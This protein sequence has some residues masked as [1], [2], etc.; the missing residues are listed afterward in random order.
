MDY[1]LAVL[2][3]KF[4]IKPGEVNHRLT[5]PVII[6][7]IIYLYIIMPARRKRV[8]M[9]FKFPSKGL[10]KLKKEVKVI[11]KMVN[12]TIENKQVNFKQVPI[13]VSNAAYDAN[14]LGYL[15]QPFLSQGTSDGTTTSGSAARVGNSITMMRTQIKFNFDVSATSENYNKF[16][17]IVCESSEGAQAIALG[18]IL[19]DSAQ[20]MSS[21]YT[22]KSST[23]K[24]YDVKL[25]RVFECNR[26]GKGSKQ[27]T[28]NI[29]YGK[30][31]RVVNY[32]GTSAAPTDYKLSIL[33]VTDS[34][35]AP[36]PSMEYT[37]RHIYKDA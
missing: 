17:L 19:L 26:Y 23:N 14:A 22:T 1:L 30:A 9:R 24:R 35:V 16:R 36:H 11:K 20:P 7:I 32:D 34:T 28:L 12:S 18:D 27:I 21:Q 31:G 8:D 6:Y 5:D 29:R 2:R 10:K 37:L 33:C 13:F 3:F 15:I 25:D 4:L